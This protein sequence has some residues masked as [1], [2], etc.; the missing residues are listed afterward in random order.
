VTHPSPI[1]TL[2]S[3]RRLPAAALAL[4]V[5]CGDAGD[6]DT[7]GP[8]SPATAVDPTTGAATSTTT[9]TEDPSSGPAASTTTAAASTSVADFTTDQPTAGTTATT[10]QTGDDTGTSGEPAKC[11]PASPTASAVC[12]EGR[13]LLVGRREGG[14][15]APVQPY[16][17]AGVCWAPT[18]I[19]E[20]NTQGYAD[21]YIQYGGV[22]APHIQALG[23][24]TI[25]TYDPFAQTPPRW[26]CSTT[27]TPAGSWSQCP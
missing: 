10:A 17:I 23:A 16:R 3:A 15:L 7:T 25:K 6:A 20:A 4:L 24:N 9:T 19:G 5:A 11:T 2:S 12:V 18:G 22:D 14:V 13:Q 27:C 8:T 1:S 26:P 21:Y